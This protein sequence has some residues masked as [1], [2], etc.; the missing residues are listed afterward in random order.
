METLDLMDLKELP[1]NFRDAWETFDSAGL[2][3]D[4]KS[5]MRPEKVLQAKILAEMMSIDKERA[6]TSMKAWITFIQVA[7]RARHASFKTLADY[8]RVRIIDVGEL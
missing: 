3:E 8:V 5:T 4:I 6:I 1:V 7:A 2:N